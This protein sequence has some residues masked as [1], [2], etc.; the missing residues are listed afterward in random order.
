MLKKII[1]KKEVGER[2]FLSQAMDK[3]RGLIRFH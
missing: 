2:E 3:T 1:I